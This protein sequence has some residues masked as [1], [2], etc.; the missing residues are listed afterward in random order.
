MDWLTFVSELVK[1]IAWPITIILCIV[2]LRKPLG[3]LVPF[4][5]TIKYSDVE[6]QFGREVAK[7]ETVAEKL[8]P[9]SANKPLQQTRDSLVQLAAVRPRTAIRESWKAV[10]NAV[11]ECA[12]RERLE[13][14]PSARSM[15]MVVG[16]LI[17]NRGTVSETQYA[18]GCKNSNQVGEGRR[19]RTSDGFR[20][21]R[22]KPVANLR[23]RS[24]G[25]FRSRVTWTIHRSSV[26]QCEKSVEG[27]RD[28]AASR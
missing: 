12:T 5:R 16:S 17:F 22:A 7:S 19:S 10:E 11:L 25:S 18:V 27:N 15:P 2:F 9:S 26:S 28:Y 24:A 1:S 4:L 6:L 13:L 21:G 14:A 23:G 20:R 8:P 3:A